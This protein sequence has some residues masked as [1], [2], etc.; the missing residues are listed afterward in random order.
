MVPQ[1]GSGQPEPESKGGSWED[2]GEMSQQ[3][4]VTQGALMEDKG[5]HAS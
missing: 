4:R 2:L 5:E 1:G 3:Y